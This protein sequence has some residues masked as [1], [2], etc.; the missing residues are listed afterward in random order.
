MIA[1]HSVSDE[2]RLIGIDTVAVVQLFE[3]K[4]FAEASLRVGF[5]AAAAKRAGLRDVSDAAALLKVSLR[6]NNR[7]GIDSVDSGLVALVQE[8]ER[9][10]AALDPVRRPR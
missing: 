4:R 10:S 7:R 9:A 3:Q 1:K 6:P 2:V 8:V 5:I